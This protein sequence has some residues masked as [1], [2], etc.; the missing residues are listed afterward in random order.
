MKSLRRGSLDSS[1][2]VSP[3]LEFIC[4]APSEADISLAYRLARPRH[5][6]RG[7]QMS[8]TR[9]C[10]AEVGG[11][12][13]WSRKFKKNMGSFLLVSHNVRSSDER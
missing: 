2:E 5:E 9:V 13:A 8:L 7:V 4:P 12:H 6:V 11:L 3:K 1:E 10:P